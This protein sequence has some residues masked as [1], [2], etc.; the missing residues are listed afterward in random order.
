MLFGHV[1]L[2]NSKQTLPPRK[3][4]IVAGSFAG[5]MVG[6]L[7]LSL[8]LESSY[9]GRQNDAVNGIANEFEAAVVKDQREETYTHFVGGKPVLL[10]DHRHVPGRVKVV[11]NRCPVHPREPAGTRRRSRIRLSCGRT[12]CQSKSTK[13]EL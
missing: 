13:C 1:L 2:H 3:S 6:A 4:L 11:G 7:V 9:L 12:L 10:A 8:S 5:A